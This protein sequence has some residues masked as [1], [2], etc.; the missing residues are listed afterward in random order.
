MHGRRFHQFHMSQF[1][2]SSWYSRSRSAGTPASRAA[3]AS[4]AYASYIGMVHEGNPNVP[5]HY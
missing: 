2:P 5:C 3:S 4:S 1:T